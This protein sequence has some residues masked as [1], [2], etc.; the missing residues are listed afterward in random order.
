MSALEIHINMTKLKLIF[1]SIIFCSGIYAIPVFLSHTDNNKKLYGNKNSQFPLFILN[2]IDSDDS[3]ISS[4]E[5]KKEY[6]SNNLYVLSDLKESL[7]KLFKCDNKK[8]INITSDPG[9]VLSKIKQNKKVIVDFANIDP[10]AGTLSVDSINYFNDPDNYIFRIE[11][12]NPNLKILAPEKV[13]IT[14]ISMTGVTAITRNTGLAADKYGTAF[15][16]EKVKDEFSDS[17]FVHI[18]NEVSIFPDCR[19]NWLRTTKFC[20]KERD[21]EAFKDIKVNIVEITGNHH[22]DYGE[23]Y[24][25]DTCELYKRH[26]MKFFG[27][28]RNQIEAESPLIIKIRNN[29]KIGFIGFNES[30][31]TG[32]CSDNKNQSGA[33]RYNSDKAKSA[34]K[35]MKENSRVDFIIA[36]VQFNEDDSYLP[37]ENQKKISEFLI[38]SGADM[39]FGSQAHQVQQVR[40]YKGKYIY[41][42]LGNFLFD[43]VQKTGLREGMIVHNYFFNGKL[44][45]SIPVFTFIS[46]ERR[47]VKADSL[48]IKNIRKNI[49]N[50]NLLYNF[51]E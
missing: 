12:V 38:D 46:N 18:S 33:N 34:I 39:V 29:K 7:D 50:R 26:G 35:K 11:S 25:A 47:P 6:C 49:Y 15:L 5:L 27:G 43:Q 30:C 19:Y 21:F 23:Q 16:T 40:H 45:Q 28:G 32:E 2:R 3:T 14:K 44:V 48:Q 36:T 22:K 8:I 41:Y 1:I 51:S 31:S 10:L 42:G 4:E 24:Y 9:A 13:E 20:T 17:D 37:S